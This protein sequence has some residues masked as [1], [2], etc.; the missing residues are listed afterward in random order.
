MKLNKKS[1]LFEHFK[2]NPTR[3]MPGYGEWLFNTLYETSDEDI[4]R[5][6][7]KMNKVKSDRDLVEFLTKPVK[8]K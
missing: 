1:E 6:W 3:D 7:L 8:P 4:D 5:M 2:D